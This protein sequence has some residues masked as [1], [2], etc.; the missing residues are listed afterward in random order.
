MRLFIGI[1]LPEDLKKK[2]LVFQ[3]ELKEHGMKGSWKAQENFHIT[4]EFLGEVEPNLIS[5]LTETL[6]QV[7]RNHQPFSLNVSGLGVFPSWQ[8]PHTLWTAL[9]GDLKELNVIRDE[10]HRE[11]A[12]KGFKL[13]ERPFRPHLTLASRPEIGQVDLSSVQAKSLGEFLVTEIVLF[14]SKA[15]RGKRIYTHLFEEGLVE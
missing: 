4:L 14:E 11:L 5:M 8:R 15:I 3:T 6:S 9:G 12:Q 10:L 13:E 1:D 2:L 7:V